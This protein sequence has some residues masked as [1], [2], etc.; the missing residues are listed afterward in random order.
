MWAHSLVQAAAAAAA[1]A[2]PAQLRKVL[3]LARHRY[4]S[5][6]VFVSL[7]V[8]VVSVF[9]ALFFPLQSAFG[10][11]DS[12]LAFTRDTFARDCVYY[13]SRL[14]WMGR[15]VPQLMLNCSRGRTVGLS[16]DGVFWDLMATG[17]NFLAT[18]VEVFYLQ[19]LQPVR[20]YAAE[21]TRRVIFAGMTHVLC[22][23]VLLQCFKSSEGPSP[24]A[25]SVFW[26]MVVL[27]SIYFAVLLSSNV[28]ISR[29]AT[30]AGWTQVMSLCYVAF[31]ILRFFPQ[32][33]RNHK[34]RL[35]LGVDINATI[36]DVVGGVSLVLF[37]VFSGS[38]ENGGIPLVVHGG[39]V[40]VLGGSVLVQTISFW[41]ILPLSELRGAME[42]YICEASPEE[43][44]GYLAAFSELDR[45]AELTAL[46]HVT[47]GESEDGCWICCRCTLSNDCTADA[48]AVCHLR[49]TDNRLSADPSKARILNKAGGSVAL[50]DDADSILLVGGVGGDG[51]ERSNDNDGDDELTVRS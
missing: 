26:L 1:L 25:K 7:F 23:S 20:V 47:I 32:L 13:L 28:S 9:C 27:S 51:G 10:V 19:T 50:I 43:S 24:L 12:N 33:R 42:K 16:A 21:D 38:Y 35:V 37:V 5:G 29:V 40:C 36:L 31:S 30:I 18:L 41:Y 14:C 11:V 39:S 17:C 6:G 8:L 4:T 44:A 34:Y 49:R 15:Y 3:P 46:E 48:C 2:S 22:F 45:P